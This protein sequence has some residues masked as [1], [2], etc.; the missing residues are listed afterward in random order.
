M[1]LLCHTCLLVDWYILTN[2]IVL[3]N[4][5][6]KALAN[7]RNPMP[8]VREAKKGQIVNIKG[9]Y[10]QI[11]QIESKSPS[12]R[13]AQTLYKIRFSSIPGSHKLEQ[14]LTGDIELPDVELEKKPVTLLFR[15]GNECTFMDLDNYDQYLV[16]TDTI[17]NQLFYITDNMEGLIALVISGE[18]F[19]IELPASVALEI[20]DTSP[21][22]KGASAAA[23]TKTARLS[24]GLDVQV[25]EYLNNGE[26]IKINTD[27]GKFMSRA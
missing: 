3:F 11:R 23:R 1:K 21:G 8:Y 19:A 2:K 9:E 6:F 5:P 15:E 16:N 27:T 10:Y 17:K 7:L 12:A 26:V 20:V 13:G 4:Q 18:V 22:I 25:P 14:T 24:T